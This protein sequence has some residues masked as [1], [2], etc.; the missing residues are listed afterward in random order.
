MNCTE[1]GTVK[2]YLWQHIALFLPAN[3]FAANFPHHVQ[4]HS[5]AQVE[6]MSVHFELMTCS[7]AGANV[8]GLSAVAE[9]TVK[10]VVGD[11][12]VAVMA[13]S[14]DRWCKQQKHHSMYR[15]TE[16]AA[17]FDSAMLAAVFLGL[18]EQER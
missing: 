3:D 14:D 7:I 10:L 15:S 17:T 9:A 18:A 16:M 4:L 12:A 1:S 6:V 8:D 5:N 2:C 13:Q 11:A